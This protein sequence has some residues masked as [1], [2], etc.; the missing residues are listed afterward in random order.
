VPPGDSRV[1]ADEVTY[2]IHIMIRV[3]LERALLSGDLAAADLPGAWSELYQSYL[4][5][6]PE[7]DRSGCL[8][9]SHWAE[10]LIGYF[11]TYTLG[12][13]Y[14]AQIFDAAGRSLGLLDETFARGDFGGFLGWLRQN[15]HRHGMRYRSSE[16]VKRISGQGPDASILIGHLVSR[17]A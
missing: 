13:V 15:I 4:G 7:D 11:P 1:E 17:Y 5:V 9:D 10:G 3:E 2:N 8:Q 14:A 12:N 6:V 16:I